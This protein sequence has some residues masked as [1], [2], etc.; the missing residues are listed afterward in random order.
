MRRKWYI[1][2]IATFL[3]MALTVSNIEPAIAMAENETVVQDRILS[4]TDETSVLS[5][6]QTE[7]TAPQAEESVAQEQAENTAPQEE[8][9]IA[10]EQT[11]DGA[12]EKEDSMAQEQIE[13]SETDATVEESPIMI[14]ETGYP[15]LE[16]AVAGAKT[17]DTII[18]KQDTELGSCLTI[19]KNLTITADGEDRKIIRK[20]GYRDTLIKV[21]SGAVLSFGSGAE[22]GKV[23]LDGGADWVK[24]IEVEDATLPEG[25]RIDTVQA[26]GPTEEGVYNRGLKAAGSMI[27]VQNGRL[28]LLKDGVL[29]N[30][31]LAGNGGAIGTSEGGASRSNI[32]GTICGNY[33]SGNGGAISSNGYVDIY[34]TAVIQENAAAAQGGVVNNWGGGVMTIHGGTFTGNKA[35]KGGVVSTDG[36]LEIQSGSMSGNHAAQGGA[37]YVVSSN[38]GRSALIYGGSIKENQAEKGADI[39]QSTQHAKF[40]GNAEIGE[41]Y[42]PQGLYM[43]INGSLSGSIGI[44]A[45]TDPGQ[46]GLLAARGDGYTLT[47]ADAGH[48][49]SVSDLYTANYKANAVYLNYSPVVIEE[50]PESIDRA[51]IGAEVSFS[52]KGQ[53]PA[54]TEVSYQ[55]YECTDNNGNDGKELVGETGDTLKITKKTPGVY[56]YYCVL[57]APESSQSRT[58]VVSVKFADSTS[59]DLPVITAQ[60]ED[61]VFDLQKEGEISIGASVEDNG[62]LSYQ[63]YRLADPEAEEGGAIADANEASFQV[64]TQE[65]GTFYYYC[66]VTN[67]NET[68]ENKTTSVRSRIVTVQVTDAVVRYND[69]AYSSLDDA[70]AQIDGETDG[71]LEILKDVTMSRTITVSAGNLTIKAME[72]TNPVMKLTP[73]LTGEAFL[74]KGGT[75]TLE[76]ITLDGGAIWWGTTHQVL[77]RGTNNRGREV[78]K[79]LITMNGGTVN[80]EEGTVFQNNVVPW[81]SA[82][83]V[84]SSGTLN[85]NGAQMNDCYGGSHGGVIYSSGSNCKI[86]IANSKFLRNQARSST[87]AICGDLGTSLSISNTEIANN[88]TVGRAGA[89]F[90]NGTLNIS[91]NT[92]IH[93]NYAGGNGGGVLHLT[94]T[95]T[96]DGGSIRNNTAGGNGGGIASLGGTLTLNGGTVFGNTATANGNGIYLESGVT[97][98]GNYIPV[99]VTDPVYSMKTLKL[100]L[101]GNGSSQSSQQT[102]RYLG[103]YELPELQRNGYQFLGWFTDPEDGEQ[104]RTGERIQTRTN[105]TLYAHWLLTASNV[106]TVEGQPQGGTL[107]VE[108]QPRLTVTASAAS[109]DLNY[110]WYR[111]GDETGANAEPV[112]ENQASFALPT[113]ES[114]IGTYYYYCAISAVEQNAE[115]V[116]TEVVKVEL[117]SRNR[118]S[119]PVFTAEPSDG[120]L[121]IGEE[122]ELSAQAVVNDEGTVTYQWY[123]GA[124]ADPSQAEEIEGATENTY[125]VRPTEAGTKYYFVKAINKKNNTAGIEISAEIFS[126]GA[127]IVSHEK[128]SVEQLTANNEVLSQ[129]YWNTYR[130][131]RSV[132]EDG[133]ISTVSSKYGN[134]AGNP[135]ANAFDGKFNTFWETNSGGVVN[136]V[137]MTFS[138]EVK[139]DRIAYATRQDG[140]A[141]RGYPTKLTVY[142]K[143]GEEGWKE[144]GVA[145]S[146]ESNGYILFTFPKTITA[147]GLRMEFT[148]STYN[149]WASA[150][151]IILLRD[152]STVLTGSAQIKGNAVPGSSLMVQPQILTGPKEDDVVGLQS[153]VQKSGEWTIL[154]EKGT[155]AGISDTF[156]SYQWQTS[157][158]NVAFTDIQGADQAVYKLEEKDQNQYLRVV[159]KDRTGA[160]TG[161]IV[162][163]SYRG[164]FQAELKGNAVVGGKL[165]PEISYM[166]GDEVSYSYQWQKTNAEGVFEDIISATEES[167]MVQA[168]DAGEK[169]RVAVSVEDF[170]IYSDEVLIDVSAIITGAPQTGSTLKMSLEGV[171]GEENLDLSYQWQISPDKAEETFE[172]VK[173]GSENTYTIP[174]GLEGKYIRGLITIKA[175]GKVYVSEA[176]EILPADTIQNCDKDYVY[177]SDLPKEKMLTGTVGYGNL[178]YDR[179]TSKNRIS[180]MVDGQK[181]YF[182]K[183]FGA[184]ANATL[185][186]DVSDYVTYYH[187]ER[188]IAYLGVDSAQGNTGNGVTFQVQ[189]SEDGQH[190]TTVKTTGVLKGASNAVS[191]DIDLNGV[192]YLKIYIDMNGNSQA[193]HSVVADAKLA[194][195]SYKDENQTTDLFQTVETYDKLIKQYQEEHTGT[196]EELMEQ[197]EFRKLVYQ[198]TFVK[199]ADYQMLKAYLYD[200][201]YT[202]TLKWFLNDMEA[203]D[204]YIGGG[205]P[206][207]SYV[208]FVEAL[209]NLYCSN[210]QD[211]EDAAHGSLY[212]KMIITTALTHS[213][214]VVYWADSSVKSD[215]VRRYNI[216]KKL[217]DNGLLLNNVFENLSVEEMRWVINNISADEEIEWLNYYVRYHTNK[218]GQELNLNNFTPGPYYFI[219]YTMGFNYYQ[220]KFYSAE[221]KEMWQKKYSL[222]NETAD[223]QVAPY[224]FNI[225]YE[226]NKP[227]LWIVWEAGAVCGGISKT[228]TNLLTAFGVPGV[229]VGQPGHAAYLQYGETADGK[230]KWDINNDI[231][232]WTQTEK[233]E[234]LLNGWGNKSWRS[235]YN[236]SYVLLAQA[237]LNEEEKYFKSQE[238]VKLADVYSDDIDSQI[239]IY[240]EALDVLNLN[241][242]AWEGLINAY[243]KAGKGSEDFLKLAERISNAL[244]YYPL[245]MRDMLMNLISPQ[246]STESEKAI[247]SIYVQSALNKAKNAT[248]DNTLQPKYCI[249]MANYLLGK[250]DYQVASFSFSGDKAGTVVLSDNFSGGNEL[251]ISIDSGASWIN[252]GTVKEYTFTEEELEQISAED[253][254]R[255]RLQ[256]TTSYYT[257]DI[258]KGSKPSNLYNNDLENRITGNVTGLEWK[259]DDDG[260]TGGWQTLKSETVFEGDQTILV[261]KK[262]AGKATASDATAYSF[263][264]D[265]EEPSR[266]YIP[267]GS[268]TLESYSSDQPDKNG[269]VQNILDGNI[270]TWWHTAWN[271]SDTQRY[272]KLKFDEPR[273]LTSID[274]LPSGGNGT[275]QN[276]EVYTSMDGNA[277]IL[278]GTANGWAADK[279]KK[280]LDLYAP[281]YT[282]YVMI[283]VTKG[284]NG[285]ASGAMLE[286][287]EDTTVEDKTVERLELQSPPTKT[288]YMTGDELDTAGLSVRAYYDDG[289]YSSINPELLQFTPNIFRETGA[290]T[291]T[292]SYR[293]DANVASVSFEVSVEENTR[294]ADRIEIAQVPDKTRYFVGDTTDLTGLEVKAHYTDDSTGYLFED[295]YTVTPAIL[296][297]DGKEVPVTVS[298]TQGEETLTAQFQVEVTKQVKEIKVT[299]KPEK[300]SYNLG[301]SFVSQGLEVT[302]VYED[303]T[304]EV[305]DSSEYTVESEGFSNTSGNKELSIV[306]N[307]IPEIRTECEILVYPYI[308]EGCLQ[309]ES[310]DNADTAY[311]SGVSDESLP[312]DGKVTVP[313]QVTVEGKL[314]FTVTEIGTG[315]F[316]GKNGITSVVIPQTVQNI[317][318]GAFTG[319][320]NLKEVYL[321]AYTDFDGFTVA[322]D[323]FGTVDAE[324]AVQG[325]IYVAN[326]QLAQQLQD[327]NLIGLK[328]F[329]IVPVTEKMTEIKVTAPDKTAYHLGEELDLTGFSVTGVLENQE[330]LRL[331][332]N[333]Y[334]MSAF[335]PDRAGEQTITVTGKGTQLSDSFVVTVTPEEPVI[336]EQPESR[337]YDLTE[338]PEPLQVK[339]SVSDTGHLQYQW[340]VSE[341]GTEFQKMNSETGA[342]C[343]V[344]PGE[345]RYYYAEVINN[346]AQGAEETAVKVETDK[347]KITFGNYEA[348]VGGKA[349]ETLKA[350]IAVAQEGSDSK[351]TLIK[352]VILTNEI[353][354]GQD[355]TLEGYGVYRGTGY[356]G[357]LFNITAGKVTLKNIIIDGGA[358]WS[359]SVDSILNRGTS[360]SGTNEATGQSAITAVNTMIYINGGE[361]KLAEGASLQNNYN[362]G[363]NYSTDGGAVKI[364]SGVLRIAGGQI[365]NNYSAQYGGAVLSIGSSRVI[366]EKGRVA[367]NHG[368]SSGGTFCVDA[369]ST[370]TME[371]SRDENLPSIIEDNR[372]NTNGGVIWLSNGNVDLNGGI[373][374]NNRANSNGGAVYI[375]GSGTVNLGNVQISGNQAGGQGAGVHVNSGS[376]NITGVPQVADAIYLPNNRL[377]RVKSNLASV[378]QKIPV[379]V[380]SYQ[381]AGDR[382]GTADSAELAKAAA[383]AFQVTGGQLPVYARGA[384]LYYGIATIVTLTADLPETA[385]VMAGKQLTLSVEGAI[386]PAQE[387]ELVYQWY[388]CND[389]QGSGAVEI[390]VSDS[391]QPNVLKLGDCAEGV[392]YFYCVVSDVAGKADPVQSA[393]CTV[394]VTKFVPALKAIEKMNRL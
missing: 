272:L 300:E 341:D 239:K 120:E 347:V 109:G 44:T 178:E 274:Y 182:M 214:N 339:A 224:D 159:I 372:G 308:T 122:T 367:G 352:N 92:D 183:G 376:I 186:F 217:Y 366:L 46:E 321:T 299:G 7:D 67:T 313:D 203:L 297:Q 174:E 119:S 340:Y 19:N 111:C 279:V 5:E 33:A 294:T 369:N 311:V 116:Q 385:T 269:A 194:R 188:F 156:L 271:G 175:T 383:G 365:V 246:L 180:L 58:E 238:L 96:M 373:I 289:T 236:G 108:D 50:Q 60:P 281:V 63:W 318:S 197:E 315:S 59:A 69:K 191:V 106:I 31:D 83:V 268:I 196:F 94:G 358:V 133:Y 270:Y 45:A 86:N 22:T 38:D 301:E 179:N 77:Q 312:A 330:E 184:H 2:S 199:A 141:G 391:G 162:S 61:A 49:H 353:S 276:V 394:T 37:V 349:Y 253:D 152:E 230:G 71:T 364:D 6:E 324:G 78:N 260:Q 169:I 41:V 171:A 388:R 79:P 158:D 73:V 265:K 205:S 350:A 3:T 88:Y 211:M 105:Q 11:E 189:T 190:F 346:D 145:V 233:G 237:A 17:G 256:G 89:V 20:E 351:V 172:D 216:Y 57:S 290:Q 328:N 193:D 107:Y 132:N 380:Q 4:E 243:K 206:D 392:C 8:D 234:R 223:P 165:T 93:D 304:E 314:Q 155:L 154:P 147:T 249:T 128:I 138:K 285:F 363:N 113:E 51:E 242:D 74:V 110:Q 75:L 213:A 139:L 13:E 293:L 323:A 25:K 192:K 354:I 303:D 331:A 181:N 127:K 40:K 65:S 39:Y 64:P 143:N 91:G 215:A 255:V 263:K 244:T 277:W 52:V 129:A 247:L 102:V 157:S 204:L 198:R 15:T 322:E 309:L 142:S 320:E 35:D 21:S 262:A 228:G 148:K 258:T 9:S 43:K 34:D 55:W 146:K 85:M 362:N 227:R 231:S 56:Y 371:D 125:I 240:E 95:F 390:A 334:E 200:E 273:Y 261:R 24:D 47:E 310:N 393:I 307:R 220:E 208:N 284:V 221:N 251:L 374:R 80:L 319:C 131:G 226:K 222:T 316:A 348:R 30:N 283:K 104:V 97:V 291:V 264:A 342:S 210:G 344:I 355:L 76:G 130:I 375:A 124:S 335:E 103:L 280:T 386:E 72:G 100:T 149:N 254:I 126:R 296:D 245:P 338:F 368:R 185:I 48:I 361:L 10:Q 166:T 266:K 160:F 81:T 18:L 140:L 333:L 123:T 137:E 306:Y 317:A 241:L 357:R 16:D 302:V 267:L 225:T 36:K 153:G 356:T 53:A 389:A 282:S 135:I 360:N 177:L 209:K 218:K 90:I 66:V 377:I 288:N 32:R 151:E 98:T 278:S 259:P 68:V 163:D 62:T 84:M 42:L 167:Y 327:K 287:F 28:E 26:E 134:Y 201:S 161:S 232:G 27:W 176:W 229:V 99:E 70:L 250:T 326:A 114:E 329:L 337:E 12:L 101:D 173:D 23:I 382:F 286:F 112:G 378:S 195:K 82:G 150:S 54:Q 219:T 379:T 207:G 164:S 252:A 14:G 345:T 121:F 187:Y 298:Y 168:E 235:Y 248:T 359:G 144:A 295:Q 292:A 202:E 325:T 212:K 117:I 343:A 115:D 29:R 118:A 370:F 305:L 336:Q 87:G 387:G 257:I 332:S 384:D 275:F 381:T 170:T 136:Q 1:K